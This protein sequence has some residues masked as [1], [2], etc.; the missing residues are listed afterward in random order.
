MR[1]NHNDVLWVG[2]GNTGYNRSVSR[3]R[4]DTPLA[5]GKWILCGF[6]QKA[7]KRLGKLTGHFAASQAFTGTEIDFAKAR[8][9]A[10]LQ[11]T[12]FRCR[13]RSLQC[14][15]KRRSKELIYWIMLCP[16]A[17]GVGLLMTSGG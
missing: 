1:D 9:D 8:V 16:P 10:Y 12:G 15:T 7:L 5:V 17:E 2:I 13:L 3:N 14:T 11:P 4:I 6:S